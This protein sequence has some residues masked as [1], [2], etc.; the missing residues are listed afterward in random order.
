LQ[1]QQQQQQHQQQHPQQP[2]QSKD[3]RH[4]QQHLHHL[5]LLG[6]AAEVPTCWA[7]LSYVMEDASH[8]RVYVYKCSPLFEQ[9]PGS[10]ALCF[11]AR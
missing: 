9:Q 11:C 2:P 7:M 1:Q 10:H 4:R 8:Q 3:S 5:C 6:S